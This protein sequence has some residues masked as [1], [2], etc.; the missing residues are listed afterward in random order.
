MIDLLP[1]DE[2]QAVADNIA[3]VLM[4]EAPVARLRD[5][6]PEDA[7]LLGRL[8]TLGWIGMGLA[9][10]DGGVGYGMAEEVLLFRSAGRH[11]IGPGLLAATLAA[12]L[13]A[14]LGDTLIAA[15]LTAGRA[16]VAL[17][18]PIDGVSLG[19]AVSG[20]F[21]RL[22]GAGC[23]Y[24]LIV[25]R[26]GAAL[27]DNTGLAAEPRSG[28]DD[29]VALE[30][31]VLIGQAA[32]L[33]LPSDVHR[34]DLRADILTS[35]ILTGLSE[36]ARD[37]AVDYA[38]VREQFGQPIGAFQAIKHMC[39]DMAVRSEAAWSLV[40]FAA[41]ALADERPDT[42]FQSISARLLAEDAATRNAAKTIQVHGGIGYTAECDAQLFLKR[43]RLWSGLGSSRSSRLRALL[44]QS[45]PV[46]AAREQAR[47]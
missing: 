47:R 26:E 13:A 12:H 45:E 41:L 39:A 37:L 1:D 23:D 14:R 11:L 18:S 19:A 32:R 25:T 33:W 4:A 35:A 40:V 6:A 34:L 27:I 22:D 38:K 29:A 2:Q 36:G 3:E 21:H 24:S 8:A 30:R 28:L 10:A 16:S 20:R 46:R 31:V 9:E 7:G 44:D 43:A 15:E 5:G 42:E 17:M